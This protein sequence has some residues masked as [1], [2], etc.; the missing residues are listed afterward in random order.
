MLLLALWDVFLA[1][2]N[3]YST[4][5]YTIINT[6]S[7]WL[8]KCF[9]KCQWMLLQAPLSENHV[10][11]SIYDFPGIICSITADFQIHQNSPTHYT[12]SSLSLKI[13]RQEQSQS[14]WRNEASNSLRYQCVVV[15]KKMTVTFC[16]CIN[17]G[18]SRFLQIVPVLAALA[19]MVS[20]EDTRNGRTN[21]SIRVSVHSAFTTNIK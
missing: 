21:Y 4:Q 8:F 14:P 5:T 2:T 17:W 13:W 18:C 3:I 20:S 19:T 7:R 9:P 1:K 10:L 15:L 12:S 11:T 6:K 16:I